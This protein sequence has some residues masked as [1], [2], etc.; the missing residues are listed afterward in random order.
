MGL[1]RLGLPPVKPPSLGAWKL[2]PATPS[3]TLFCRQ[4]F[5]QLG[6]CLGHPFLRLWA[7]HTQGAYQSLVA[8][9]KGDREELWARLEDGRPGSSPTPLLGALGPRL[10]ALTFF[11]GLIDGPYFCIGPS[12]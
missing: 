7:G 6:L 8:S 10:P 12:S 9:E 2:S 3:P 4:A 11:I 5:V 1:L